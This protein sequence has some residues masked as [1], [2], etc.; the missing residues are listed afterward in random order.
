MAEAFADD[1][2]FPYAPP[3]QGSS[4][5]KT[6]HDRRP[7]EILLP[8]SKQ[9]SF[10]MPFAT[11]WYSEPRDVSSYEFVAVYKQALEAAGWNVARAA[12]AGDAVVVAHYAKNGRDLWLYTR[13]D[14]TQQSM[15]VD[16]FGAEAE[17]SKLKQELGSAGHVALYGIYFDTDSSVPRPESETTLL[18]VL[19]LLRSDPSLR[20]EIQGRTDDTGSQEHNASLSD[21]R[22]ASVRKWLTDHEIAAARLTSKGYGSTKPVADNHTPEGRAK[23]RGVELA[24]P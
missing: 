6:V 3:F 4:L 20:L 12:V 13:A 18:E 2:D 15:S 17:A 7:F 10:A 11:R 5:Q 14:G 9:P 8:D 19:Q 16:D 1:R 23:N 21:A 24:K 22:A